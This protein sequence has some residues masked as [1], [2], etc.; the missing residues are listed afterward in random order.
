MKRA[1]LYITTNVIL[2]AASQCLHIPF[3]AQA[4]LLNKGDMSLCSMIKPSR[5]AFCA[6]SHNWQTTPA[7]CMQPVA[8]P[9]SNSVLCVT[10][11]Y[12]L[13]PFP[14]ISCFPASHNFFDP[15]QTCMTMFCSANPM[16]LQQGSDA[17]DLDVPDMAQQ[18]TI[19]TGKL[20]V[21]KSGP[22]WRKGT[23][24]DR[25]SFLHH[26]FFIDVSRDICQQGSKPT[27]T[28]IVTAWRAIYDQP[29]ML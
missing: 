24:F 13:Q 21:G 5:P 25:K 16:V 12:D 8:V 1:S 6:G 27:A 20:Q 19:S 11:I 15:S 17:V 2:S 23:R 18:T 14:A 26:I 3:A 7:S 29:S 22:P 10:P 28:C 9:A 4:I